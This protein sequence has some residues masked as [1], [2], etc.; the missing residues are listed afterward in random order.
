MAS[1]PFHGRFP[2]GEKPVVS[3]D[4]A[5]EDT[6]GDRGEPDDWTAL[7][8]ASSHPLEPQDGVPWNRGMEGGL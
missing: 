4:D 7:A 5:K 6:H 8:M 3:T 1:S 2:T